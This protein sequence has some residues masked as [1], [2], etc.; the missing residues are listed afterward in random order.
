[1]VGLPESFSVEVIK[2]YI[3]LKTGELAT[4]QEIIAYCTKELAKYKV[5]KFVEF[6]QEL[7]KTMIGKVLRRELLE[8]E[9]RKARQAGAG[10]VGSA[11]SAASPATSPTTFSDRS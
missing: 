10:P 9:L 3:V 2:A 8:E 4:P 7:P 6:R 5:P 1:V 11:Q